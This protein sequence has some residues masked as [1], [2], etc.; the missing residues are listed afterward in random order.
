MYVKTRRVFVKN[1]THFLLT[2]V[3]ENQNFPST[4]TLLKANVCKPYCTPSQGY[5]TSYHTL[6]ILPAGVI[7]PL[8]N[9]R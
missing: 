9:L 4:A 1:I 7:Q 2:L 8:C 6:I 3:K 5:S